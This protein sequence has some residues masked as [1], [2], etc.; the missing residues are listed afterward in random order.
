MLSAESHGQ[1][2]SR[3]VIHFIPLP[4]ILT[5][6]RKAFKVPTLKIGIFNRINSDIFVELRE[7]TLTISDS[8]EAGSPVET[9]I[10]RVVS[11]ST[12]EI[13]EITRFKKK[14]KNDLQGRIP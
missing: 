12:T 4:C 10:V 8:I 9:E 2:F 3:T 5:V 6:L 14:K 1:T 11:L 7:T 13:T